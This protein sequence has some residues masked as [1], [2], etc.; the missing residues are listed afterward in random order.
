MKPSTAQDFSA[1]EPP[2]LRD[3]QKVRAEMADGT[4]I[5]GFI[6][7]A[8]SEK[9]AFVLEFANG[10]S[11]WPITSMP[12]HILRNAQYTVLEEPVVPEPALFGAIVEAASPRTGCQRW[13]RHGKARDCI[14]GEPLWFSEDGDWKYGWAD[15]ISPIIV[16]EG[17]K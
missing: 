13:T 14:T 10:E 2:T 11:R 8:C 17:V 7:S 16:F 1:N 12:G 6:G 5:I 3:G 9:Y 4:S 15:L